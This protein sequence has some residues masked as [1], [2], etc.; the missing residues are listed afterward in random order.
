MRACFSRS[1]AP[2]GPCGGVPASNIYTNEIN[3]DG[4]PGTQSFDL[5][6]SL[7][8]WGFHYPVSTYARPVYGALAPHG[9]LIL[10]VRRGTAGKDEL[11]EL[12]GQSPTLL[13]VTEKYERVKLVK[14][15]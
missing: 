1:E 9:V 13:Q 11:A 4:F 3:R 2:G 6:I 15:A 8:S 7:I 12:F 10:D 14:S 5:V